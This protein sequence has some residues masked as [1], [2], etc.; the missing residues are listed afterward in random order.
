MID[1]KERRRRV[2]AMAARPGCE[3]EGQS[4]EAL[5]R[6]MDEEDRASD[7][8]SRLTPLERHMVQWFI[9]EIKPGKVTIQ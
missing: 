4:A 7:L 3:A 6:S 5:L 2:G 1:R 9:D 8:L